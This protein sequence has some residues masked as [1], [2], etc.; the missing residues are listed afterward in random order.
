MCS[1]HHGAGWCQG[2]RPWHLTSSQLRSREHP[3]KRTLHDQQSMLWLLKG[4]MQS[5][6]LPD[7]WLRYIDRVRSCTVAGLCIHTLQWLLWHWC[8]PALVC[9]WLF[10]FMFAVPDFIV[11]Q[12]Y[13]H[14]LWQSHQN[15]GIQVLARQ[16]MSKSCIQSSSNNCSQQPT[17]SLIGSCTLPSYS[18]RSLAWS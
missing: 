4:V 13:I 14:Q 5:L 10:T 6:Q 3:I 7:T 11:S 9:I 8:C 17:C 1:G 15:K 2:S 18:N 12:W 16:L